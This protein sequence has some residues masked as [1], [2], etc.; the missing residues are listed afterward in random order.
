MA[1]RLDDNWYFGIR[2]R[3]LESWVEVVADSPVRAHT[4]AP[5]GHPTGPVAPIGGVQVMTFIRVKIGMYSATIIAPMMA[6]M[7]TI[8]IG[9][10]NAVSAS[11][12]ASTS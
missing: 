12:V 1:L 2:R 10:I 6:P 11:V 9:S 3:P 7:T 8:M 4:K 5:P